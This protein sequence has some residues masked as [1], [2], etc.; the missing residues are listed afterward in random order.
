MIQLDNLPFSLNEIGEARTKALKSR[1][2]L[3][4]LDIVLLQIV[5]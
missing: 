4:Q 3:A 1:P 2:R 5:I